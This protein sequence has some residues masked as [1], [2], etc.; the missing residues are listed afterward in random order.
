MP[1]A[2]HLQCSC[3]QTKLQMTGYPI[4]V[5]ECHCDSCREA[6][7]RMTALPGASDIR[8]ENGGTCCAEVRKD[9]LR[10]TAGEENLR[11]FRV[12]PDAELHRVIATCYNTPLFFEMKGAHWVSVY[13]SLWPEENRP[14]PDVRTMTGDLDD[15]S[16]LPSDIPNLK[17]HSIGFYA[18][19][20]TAWVAMGVA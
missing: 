9:R 11:A 8:A 5:T 12:S 7:S 16:T 20:F 13:L 15:P 14:A 18:K 10:V 17:S 2:T 3:G 6:A 19:L 1:D 4:L